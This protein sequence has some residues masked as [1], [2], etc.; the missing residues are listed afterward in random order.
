MHLLSYLSITSSFSAAAAVAVSQ[1]DYSAPTAVT[2]NGTYGG[3]Y[4]SEYDQDLFLG[5]RYAQK[6][7]RFT[8]A[9]PVNETWNDIKPLTE[10]K[11]HCYGYGIAWTGSNA[12][13]SGYPMSED[14]LYLNIIR[15]AGLTNTSE[16]PVAM[17][18]HG[19]GFTKGGGSDK[20]YNYSNAVQESVNMGKPFIGITI[21]YRLSAWG[22]L[23]GKEA[24][25]AGAV[26]LGYHDMRQ[27]LRWVNENIAAFGGDPA[28]V[29]IVGESCGAEALAAQI[30]AYGGRDD[31]LFRAAI[32]ESGFGGRVPRPWP[33]GLNGTVAHQKVFDRLVNATSCTATVGTA[34]A[35]KCL[36]DVPTEELNHAINATGNTLWAPVFDGDFIQDYPSN[37]F[38]D[39]RFVRV[40]I[41][42]GCN[43]DEGAYFRGINGNANVTI[44]NTD[45][46][47]EA[48]VL[49]MFDT[50]DK[51]LASTGKT[52]DQLLGEI[53]TS[54]PNIQSVGIPNLVAWP[55]V[56]NQDTPD[57]QYLGLQDRRGN[58]F[59]GDYTNIAWRRS[60][61]IY[62][63]KHQ[64]PNWSYR[65]DARADGI[66]PNVSAQH[67]GEVAYVF[68]NVLG[69]GYRIKPLVSEENRRLAKEVSAAWINMIT[70]LNPN[71]A[72]VKPTWPVYNATVGGGVGQNMVFN[73]QGSFVEYDDFRAEALAWWHSH[74]LDLMG[75]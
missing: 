39:G 21:N 10:Y 23:M 57:L 5:I 31:G 56:V 24:Q 32:G 63:S 30:L 42:I 44:L 11:E 18:I 28:K 62:W 20:R 47:F 14:C 2:K 29:T 52:V 26:N 38:R 7:V 49:P 45:A 9:E 61:N 48:M 3:V 74:F 66:L 16:L 43:S 25:E 19:G 17:W 59:G 54:Y 15:P 69:N 51:V 46:D 4:V 60:S 73:K 70:G 71:G 53:T 37:Q 75:T 1:R 50:N 55:E 8:R 72:G 58:A 64:I 6:V 13:W 40:P 41:L 22:W 67:F 35:I 33:G 12:D 36:K 65:F 27:A 34:Q 68:N